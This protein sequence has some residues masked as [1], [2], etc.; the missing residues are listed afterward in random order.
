M[1]LNTY[2][3][4]DSK[5]SYDYV[6]SDVFKNIPVCR[7]STVRFVFML[8]AHSIQVKGALAFLPFREL[9]GGVAI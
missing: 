9:E 4:H 2:V 3:C 1:C 5:A 7:S 8:L 6:Y